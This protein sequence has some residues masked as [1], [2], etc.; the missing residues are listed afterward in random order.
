M[1]MVPVCASRIF[2]VNLVLVRV[3]FPRVNMYEHVVLWLLRIKVEKSVTKKAFSKFIQSVRLDFQKSFNLKLVLTLAK[4]MDC[5][6][7]FP[8][9]Y[10]K[11]RKNKFKISIRY[12]TYV[13]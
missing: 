1:G 3:S 7:F 6:Y 4:S 5:A 10:L 12:F 9:Q 11:Q 8:W 13:A 2:S